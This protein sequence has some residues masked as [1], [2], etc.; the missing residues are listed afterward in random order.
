M[1]MKAVRNIAKRWS[2][3][4]AIVVALVA[5]LC[6]AATATACP[7]CRDALADNPRGQSLA[8]GFYFSIL[9]MMSMPFLVLGTLGT[10][11][12]RSIQRAQVD[13]APHVPGQPESPSVEA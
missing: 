11:F 5:V 9:F 13:P 7:N 2:R 6:I 4:A 12:Y 10:V 1:D 8:K 3:S